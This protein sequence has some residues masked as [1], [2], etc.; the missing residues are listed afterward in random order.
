MSVGV[1]LLAAFIGVNSLHPISN[2]L[3][4]GLELLVVGA[5]TVAYTAGGLAVLERVEDTSSAT[6]TSETPYSTGGD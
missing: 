2:E 3:Q 4:L 5:G 6:S 1:V